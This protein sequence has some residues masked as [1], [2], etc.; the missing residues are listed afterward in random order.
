MGEEATNLRS[1]RCERDR[2]GMGVVGGL[3]VTDLGSLWKEKKS[4]A[5]WDV[6]GKEG[7]W[8]P[9]TNCMGLFYFV[10][11]LANI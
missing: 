4:S 5:E 9:A 3:E 6:W 1:K 8:S 11:V 2:E 7:A 10:C